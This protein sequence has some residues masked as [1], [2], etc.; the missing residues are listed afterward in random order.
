MAKPTLTRSAALPVKW[1]FYW[2]GRIF[3]VIPQREDGFELSTV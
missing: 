1:V 2:L 3:T